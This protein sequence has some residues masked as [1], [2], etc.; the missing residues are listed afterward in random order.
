MCL[1]KNMNKKILKFYVIK[2]VLMTSTYCS[3]TKTGVPT[4]MD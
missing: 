1:E 3:C 4:G 2:K